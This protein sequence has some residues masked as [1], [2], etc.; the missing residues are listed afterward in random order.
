MT[1]TQQA[2]L[3]G[4]VVTLVA[5]YAWSRMRPAMIAAPALPAAL[6]PSPVGVLPSGSVTPAGPPTAPEAIQ[7]MRGVTA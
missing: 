7:E 6:P 1:Q 2:F 5:M 3:A 4:V